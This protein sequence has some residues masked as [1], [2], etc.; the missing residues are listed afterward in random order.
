VL[1]AGFD[2]KMRMGTAEQLAAGVSL[3]RPENAYLYGR[4]VAIGEERLRPL[5]TR[6]L[7]WAWRKA[8]STPS[9]PKGLV[10]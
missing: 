8:F 5:F 3:L 2:V 9:T 1:Q 7:L 4:I 10:T 6:V